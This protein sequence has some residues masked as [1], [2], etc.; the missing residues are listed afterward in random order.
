VKQDGFGDLVPDSE[1]RVEAG[2]RLL[3]DH[4]DLPA[5]N[6]PHPV[7]RH[8]EKVNALEQ[9]L[10]SGDLAGRNVDQAHDRVCRDAL[11]TAGLADQADR[12]AARNREVDS[13]DGLDRA[14]HDVEVGLQ[15]TNVE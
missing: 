4:R 2:H 11:A 8:L 1:Y 15:A 6:M 12:A 9:N 5:S 13:V 7:R 3:E 14:V 10:A